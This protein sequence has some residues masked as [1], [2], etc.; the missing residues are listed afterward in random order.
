MG[1]VYAFTGKRKYLEAALRCARFVRSQWSKV[2]IGETPLWAYGQTKDDTYTARV[3]SLGDTVTA[4]GGLYRHT[5]DRVWLEEAQA[6]GDAI[7]YAQCQEKASVG[8]GLFSDAVFGSGK[9]DEWWMINSFSKG[10]QG[11]ADLYHATEE[12]R[13]LSALEAAA[14]GFNR[15]VD[16]A[17]ARAGADG[18][19]HI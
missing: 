16:R 10:L 19:A 2:R 8:Y 11:L 9:V 18:D 7:L 1:D 3:T 13:Y 14:V 15:E 12:R 4:F 6:L 5:R 17:G